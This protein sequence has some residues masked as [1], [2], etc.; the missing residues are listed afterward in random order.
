MV[1]LPFPRRLSRLQKGLAFRPERVW[2]SLRHFVRSGLKRSRSALAAR[3]SR[4]V[5]LDYLDELGRLGR[6]SDGAA[7]ELREDVTLVIPV[8]NAASDVT[9]LLASLVATVEPGQPVVLVDDASPD[10]EIASLLDGWADGRPGTRVIKR[11]LNGG[12]AASVNAALAGLSTHVVVLNTDVILPS[13]WLNRLMAPIDQSPETVASVTPFSNTS[14][15]TGFPNLGDEGPL[16]LQAPLEVIDDAWR[17]LPQYQIDLPSG[18][19]FCMALNHKALEHVGGF[20]SGV[21]GHGYY[22]ETDWCQRALALGFRHAASVNLFVLHKPG[23]PS[24][25]VSHRISLSE[26]NR[27]EFERR[28]PAYYERERLYRFV[29]PAAD[30]REL[31][32]LLIWQKLA[33]TRTALFAHTWGG[34]TTAFLEERTNLLLQQGALVVRVSLKDTQADL[35]VRFR[36]E[37]IKFSVDSLAALQK[38]HNLNLDRVEIHALHGVEALPGFLSQIRIF[39]QKVP[40]A[41]YL[42][43]FLPVCPTIHLIDDNGRFCHVPEP[44]RCLECLHRNF[45]VRYPVNDIVSW[46][47]L[48]APLLKEAAEVVVFN[49]TGRDYLLRAFPSLGQQQVTIRPPDYEPGLRSVKRPSRLG[50]LNVAVIG[51]LADHKGANIVRDLANYVFSERLNINII[52]IGEWADQKRPLGVKVT[53]PYNPTDLPDLLERQRINL[54]LHP[55]ICPETFSFT[56][57]EVFSMDVPVV[58]FNIGAQ[59]E[60]VARYK[61]GVT[62]PDTATPQHIV[63]AIYQAAVLGTSMELAPR[64]GKPNVK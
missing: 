42:H 7:R 57:S 39:L 53:G 5:R 10:P 60:R 61:K 56:L 24:F 30:F 13:G 48:W 43:D 8:Y 64:M 47:Q 6:S 40:Y 12:Y 62:C 50:H 38:L 26:K 55:S 31:A 27:P 3:Y 17:R 19:G 28:N 11:T 37:Q 4:G 18:C 14:S 52:V 1:P 58:A 41:I 63:Q 33:T 21:Y 22:E 36:D 16:Y 29:D 51:R 34:G 46:R 20:D 45:E 25:G 54:V 49:E 9:E 59:G 23:S 2:E 15:L 44:S 32:R 35:D